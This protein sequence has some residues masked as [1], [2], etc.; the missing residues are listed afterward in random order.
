VDY[1]LEFGGIQGPSTFR[2]AAGG[3]NVSA[4]SFSGSAPSTVGTGGAGAG[5]ADF[6]DLT[7]SLADQSGLTNFLTLL[8]RG[9][10]T[11]AVSLVGLGNDGHETYRV[12][13]AKVLVAG[14]HEVSNGGFSV[15]LNYSAIELTQQTQNPNGSTGAPQIFNFNLATNTAGG[16]VANAPE[17]SA[18]PGVPAPTHF[19]MLIDGIDGGSRDAHHQG[20]FDLNDMGFDVSQLVSATGG[21]GSGAGKAA[22]SPVSVNIAG[23]AGLTK[24]LQDLATGHSIAGARIEGVTGGEDSQVVYKLSLDGMH[25]LDVTQTNDDS[26]NAGFDFQ[27]VKLEQFGQTDTGQLVAQTPFAWDLLRATS[28]TSFDPI[29]VGSAPDAIRPVDFVLEFGGVRGPSTEHNAEGGFNVSGFSFGGSAPS[30]VNVGGGGAGA[31]KPDFSDL[32]IRLSDQSGLTSF[33]SQLAQSKGNVAASLIGLSQGGGEAYRLDLSNVLVTAVQEDSGGGFTLAL[34]YSAIEV[35]QQTQNP[36]GSTGAPQIFNFN[37]AT[38]VGGGAVQDA[39]EPPAGPGVPTPTHYFMLIDGI[40]G[41]S[42]DAHHQGWFDLNDMDFD[43]SQLVSLGGGGG[44]ASGK[45]TFSPLTVEIANQSGITKLLQDL[46]TGHAIA[47]ARIEGVTGGEDSQVVYKLSLDGMHVVGVGGSGDDGYLASFDFQQVKLEQF[48]QSNTGQLVAQTPFA[49]D[50]LHATS[51]TSF[52]PIAVG[53]TPDAVR[54][55]DFV[56]EFGGVHGPSTEHNASGGFNVSA[57]SFGASAPSVV[58]V[59]GGGVGAGK[60]DFSDLSVSFS[61]QSGL[62]DFLSQ[63]TQSKGNVAASLIGLSQDGREAYRL[64]LSRVFVTD[65]H[66]SSDGGFTV[67]LNY[68]AIEITQQT[69]NPNG[70]TGA[71]QIFNF[72]IATGVAGGAV[73]D[74]PEPSTG[75]GVAN[76]QHFYLLVNGIDGGS[77]DAHHQGWFD[78]TAMN[79]DVSQLVS[80]GGG[81]G[82]GSGKSTFS[83]VNVEV[84]NQSGITK[85]LLDLATGK[86]IVGARIE[87][88]KDG[89]D[90]QVV[91]KLDLGGVHVLQVA[92]TDDSGYQLGLDFTKVQLQQFGQDFAGRLVPT[93]TF[94][95][96]V[97]NAR[98]NPTFSPISVSGTTNSAPVGTAASATTAEDTALQGTVSGTDADGGQLTFATAAGPA[99]GTLSLGSNGAYAYTPTHDYNGTDSFTFTVSDGTATSAPTTVSLT[100]TPVNDAPVAAADTATVDEKAS[101]TLDVLGND[102][103][104]DT[105]DAKTLVSVSASAHGAGVSIVDGQVVYTASS[106]DIDALNTGQSLT[107]SFSYVMGDTAGATSTATVTLTVNGVANGPTQTGDAG[108]N[109][110]VGTG[111]DEKLDGGAGND[112]LSAGGGADTVAGGLGNDMMLGGSGSDSLSASDG[113]DT[114]VGGDG[115]DVLSGNRGNDLF[116]FGAGFGHDI[117]IDYQAG[118]RVQFQPGTG[119]ASFSDVASHMAQSGIN[120]IITD[121][122]GDTLQINSTTVA[123][124]TSHS[125]DFLFA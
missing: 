125:G 81:A 91:Y 6:S 116:V 78:L 35:T 7:V 86:S 19:F 49:W 20:W 118:D 96:D 83:P 24:L 13:L 94:G 70:T 45:P 58:G 25:V 117:I 108:D 26:Y 52:D 87:G 21:G 9:T 121:A 104:V 40:D 1:V 69:Q 28:S 41:G 36:N 95:W 12:D 55:V 37:I 109:S 11:N 14:V 65:V 100:V 32:T 56:L 92:E 51:S 33:L 27:Q 88:V 84:A 114:L 110:L 107:D 15:D 93:T 29:A 54:P 3:F 80:L 50:I 106:A 8:T 76:P 74:A 2:F 73:Q 115:N 5:K 71:P 97:A 43:V 34:N 18:G 119:F 44:G 17:P 77:T 22:F 124:L 64:D 4:F 85:L 113:T 111:L 82:S 68:S 66:E 122:A 46:A 31:G 99:H 103:D 42:T 62:T 112:T 98:P 63:L 123:T 57:F 90:S 67:D 30:V 72:N 60:P 47:G 120:V 59:G 89:E 38:G 105:G 79:F 53:S 23:Q 75:L 39:P 16:A 48:A 102:T 10:A 61:D 101:I